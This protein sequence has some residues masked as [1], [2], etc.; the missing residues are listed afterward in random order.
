[1]FETAGVGAS[2]AVILVVVVARP[3]V[4]ISRGCAGYHVAGPVATT[5]MP[6]GHHSSGI[7]SMARLIYPFV[8]AFF[9]LVTV[10]SAVA[11]SQSPATVPWSAGENLEFTVSLADI[12]S[13]TGRLQVL[14][15]E[16]IRGRRVWRLHLNVKGGIPFYHIDFTDDSWMDVESLSSLHFE[17]NQVQA[18]KTTKRIY[19]IF[20]DRQIFH[21]FG[22]EEQQSVANPLDEASLFFFVR[23]LPLEVGKQYRFDNYYD[24][25]A[26]PV[27]VRVLR[28]DTIDV[29]AGRFATIVLQPS[30]KTNGLFS[31]GGHAE[32]WLSDDARRLLVQMKT[33]FYHIS[34]GLY[35][36]KFQYD[37]VRT[38]LSMRSR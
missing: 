19:D 29:P 9:A 12:P 38:T 26:N 32:I 15:Q 8:I 31:Q 27:I 6:R 37:S 28:K 4:T 5:R 23:T 2:G 30:I 14:D 16:T 11:E 22:K 17:Q 20:P 18:G 10:G 24:P 21:Q 36:R 25:A 7:L 35:L 34:L 3:W 33:H 13:G 1:M